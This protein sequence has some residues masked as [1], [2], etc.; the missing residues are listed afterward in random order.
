MTFNTAAPGGQYAQQN[1]VAVWVTQTNSTIVKTILRYGETRKTSLS[2]WNAADGASVDGKMG[3]TRSS[4][5]AP[6]PM[7]ATWDLK[8]KLGNV[9]PDGTY[10][11]KLECADGNRQAYSFNFVK[12]SAAGTRT[13]T[14]NTY[15][16][17]ISIAY[18]PPVAN[19]APVANSQSVTN[20]EDTAKA[21]TLTATDAQSN[22]L[23]YAIATSPIHGTLSA[24][25]ATNQ[26]T[27]TPA[28]N[29]YGAD[30]FTFTA[31]D[32]SLTSTPATVSITVMPVND[33][34]VAQNQSVTNVVED[35]A[36]VI[37]LVA[38]DVETN[39]LTYAIVSNPA[40]GTL[41]AVSSNTVIYTP[42]TNYYGS[43]S[44]T[45]RA[46][47]ASLTSTPATVSIAVTPVN[48]PPVAQGQST[49]T[50]ENTAK[51]VTLVATDIE[52][53]ALTYSIVANPLH[54][55]LGAVSSNTVTYTPATN[56]YGAESFTFKAN[57]GSTD[58]VPATV[59]ITVTH[60]N[61]PPVSQNQSVT[62]VVED[63]A[64]VITLVAIDPETN[65]VT[66][67]VVTA[68][69][70]GT[71]STISSNTITYTPATNYYGSDSFAF[72]ASDGVLTGNTATV[73]ITVTPVNDPPVALAQSL[74]AT[75]GIP[76]SVTLT[77]TDAETNALTYN[78]VSLPVNGHLVGTPPSLTYI[79]VRGLN[80]SDSF[81]F[82]AFDGTVIGN[83]ATVSISLVFI[84]S[85]SNGIPNSWKSAYGVTD[86]N[87]D[88]DGDGASNYAEYM[89]GTNP[90]NKTSVFAVNVP[91]LTGG[92]N[93]VI[94]WS[95]VQYRFYTVQMSSNLIS[96][97][98]T[99]TSNNVATPPLNVYTTTVN[100]A[101]SG[102]YRVRLER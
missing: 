91:Q 70:F 29:Y 57:D 21:I 40:H 17:N 79:P 94:R 8:D 52:T 61:L 92:T 6:S 47:D 30:S 50:A 24:I 20:A 75:D 98:N 93:V 4:H 56:Y 32:A 88:P 35:T 71:L 23:T 85:S 44:F 81:T 7:T 48:D 99:L 102:F 77:A 10:F 73:S 76:V 1:V 97:W 66:Y 72:R 65:A 82:N 27:Y 89:A 2:T 54:G 86:A 34:P 45:F 41:G 18:A 74:T 95:S 80:G 96:G 100:Q 11:I 14:G 46:S 38:T 43:D 3:A 83:T 15:F 84:D 5:A 101:G 37:T 28:T 22:T 60:S 64:R 90:T 87:A 49:S 51:V 53:N 68:P 31:K 25:T 9:V 62:N 16:K 13:D 78:L 39:A 55:T 26:I 58:S 63:T 59:S 69:S 19:T 33:P 36:K 67:A 12:N 42:E